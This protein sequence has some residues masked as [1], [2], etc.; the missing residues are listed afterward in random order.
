MEDPLKHSQTT[1]DDLAELGNEAASKTVV[2]HFSENSFKSKRMALKLKS[3][4]TMLA[5]FFALLLI[6]GAAYALY[7]KGP[8]YNSTSAKEKT[9]AGAPAKSAASGSV[10]TTAKSTTV[11]KAASAT[12]TNSMASKPATTSTKTSAYTQ[13]TG[14][15]STQTTTPFGATASAPVFTD[16]GSYAAT[17]ANSPGLCSFNYQQSYSVN[18]PGSVSLNDFQT[19][20]D[21]NDGPDDSSDYGNQTF[22]QAGSASVSN[23]TSF[24]TSYGSH[25]I[26]SDY[27]QVVNSANGQVLA[28][29]PTTQFDCP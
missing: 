26:V 13:N 14:S 19:T 25:V 2:S 24:S 28:T 6:C 5:A 20:N 18:G 10:A 16:N 22:T 23:P 3:P 21:P 1:H 17:S 9:V 7:A 27:F 12:T 29:S 11:S 4:V 8:K 15:T